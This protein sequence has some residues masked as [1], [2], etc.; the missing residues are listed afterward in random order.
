MNNN[1]EVKKL[2]EVCTFING[3]AYKKEELLNCGKYTVLRVGNFFTNDNW[4]YS[5][6]ELPEDKYCDN[7]DLLYAWSASFGPRIW[8][9]NKVIYHYHIWKIV[10]K[11]S[12]ILKEFLY[13][14]LLWDTERLKKHGNGTTMVHITKGNIEN[15]S[16]SLP[17]LLEQQRIVSILNETF[18]AI[19]KAKENAEKNLQNA[20]ELFESY[21]QSVFENPGNGWKEKKL[22][23]ISSKIG[24]GATPSGGKKS[25]KTTGISLIRSLNVHDRK[26]KENNLAFLDEN[27][28]DK[29]SNVI[30][31]ENDVLLNITG[32]SIARCCIVPMEYL[33]ARV[34]QHVSI[35]RTNQDILISSFLNYLLT[36]KVYKDQLLNTGEKGGSTRQA[37]TKAQ[38][39]DFSISFPASTDEQR[40][41]VAKL[42][43]LSA[44]TKRLEAIYQQKLAALDELKKSVL[45]KA[46]N[47][48]LT[49]A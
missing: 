46:F 47:G 12:Q 16:I 29:L 40:S 48:E 43:A 10:Q 39:Q 6:L 4:Y 3:R 13:L 30:L 37:I 26:F 18:A 45:Q 36:S 33:P 8:G 34:N 14:F 22:G 17:P 15:T 44:E 7:G 32:A 25:Y 41:I 19:D 38:I 9:G 11:E 23:S 1:W 31:E 27:Q 2:G 42:D 21:L 24:S 49:G 35:I 28:A 20:R 5:D